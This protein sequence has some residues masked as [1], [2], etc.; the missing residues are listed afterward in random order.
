M[1]S[2]FAKHGAVAAVAVLLVSVAFAFLVGPAV[3]Q[4][5]ISSANCFG[6]A[7]VV[8]S[9]GSGDIDLLQDLDCTGVN[10][11]SVNGAAI[12]ITDDNRNLKLNGHTIR[13][14]GT[15]GT[16]GIRLGDGTAPN[17]VEDVEV[18]GP[19]VVTGFDIGIR[20]HL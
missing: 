1:G 3:G 4:S 20:I 5:S 17:A 2:R 7:G 8:I 12:T 16:M 9:T 10:S 14:D 19:G 13:G 18:E 15:S 11:L 6:G